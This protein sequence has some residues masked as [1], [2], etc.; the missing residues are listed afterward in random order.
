MSSA[1]IKIKQRLLFIRYARRSP[2]CK[3]CRADARRRQA[4]QPFGDPHEKACHAGQLLLHCILG[5]PL[6][7]SLTGEEQAHDLE[8]HYRYAA[9]KRSNKTNCWFLH[10][11]ISLGI[12]NTIC[13]PVTPLSKRQGKVFRYGAT[14]P[15]SSDPA[16]AEPHG[17]GLKKQ[18]CPTHLSLDLAVVDNGMAPAFLYPCKSRKIMRSPRAALSTS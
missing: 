9:V 14:Y 17:D 3:Y 8:G 6:A 10:V 15:Q 11:T 5:D 7:V 12:R 2:A 13:C 4:S 18:E 1:S 16:A